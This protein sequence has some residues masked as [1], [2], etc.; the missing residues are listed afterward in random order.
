MASTTPT[1]R[2]SREFSF[3]HL[4]EM[5]QHLDSGEAKPAETENL[6]QETVSFTDQGFDSNTSS[7]SS[8][9][10]STPD[11]LS[12]PPIPFSSSFPPLSATGKEVYPSPGFLR[13]PVMPSSQSVG[14][15]PPPV[16]KRRTLPSMSSDEIDHSPKDPR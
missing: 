4:L 5:F 15:Q 10:I 8:L 3:D 11:D 1:A 7:S 16:P 14:S 9:P 13:R 12:E 2:S 6:E